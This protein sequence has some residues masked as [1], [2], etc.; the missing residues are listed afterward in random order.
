VV[1][2][3]ALAGKPEAIIVRADLAQLDA[4]SLTTLLRQMPSVRG[5]PVVVY[6]TDGGSEA[7]EPDDLTVLVGGDS[8]DAI[9]PVVAQLF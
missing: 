1:L 8:P 3:L 5:V 4:A 7:M 2:E 9:L 6:G